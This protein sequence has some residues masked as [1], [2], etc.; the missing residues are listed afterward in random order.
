MFSV[1]LPMMRQTDFRQ[2][3]GSARS[4]CFDR[5]VGWSRWL[6][7]NGIAGPNIQK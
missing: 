6:L 7:L 4:E 1:N 2:F 5:L 3:Y